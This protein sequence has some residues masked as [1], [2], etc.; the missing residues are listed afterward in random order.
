MEMRLKS[1]CSLTHVLRDSWVPPPL[2]GLSYSLKG[3]KGAHP[4]LTLPW[5]DFLAASMAGTQKITLGKWVGFSPVTVGKMLQLQVTVCST[6][7]KQLPSNTE[8]KKYYLIRR[9]WEITYIWRYQVK[10]VIQAWWHEFNPRISQWKENRESWP[11][12]STMNTMVHAYM[13]SP[14]LTYTLIIINQT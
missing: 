9:T 13:H 7:N 12:T 3:C 14:R 5:A 8:G 1:R 2:L 11:L 10:L 4:L 6:S